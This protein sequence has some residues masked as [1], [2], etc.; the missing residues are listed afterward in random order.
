[1]YLILKPG[2][3]IAGVLFN[4]NFDGGPPFGGNKSE[5]EKLFAEKFTINTMEEC[6]N[7]IEPRKDKEVF[8][9]FFQSPIR[10]AQIISQLQMQ[11]LLPVR[12]SW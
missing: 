11:R 5:Y 3:K 12:R 7:S 9:N 10:H 1:M 4:R 8:I 6:Y 2:G